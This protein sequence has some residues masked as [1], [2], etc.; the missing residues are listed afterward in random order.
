[1]IEDSGLR[2]LTQLTSLNLKRNRYISIRGISELTNLSSIF[3]GFYN[4]M[5]YRGLKA[6]VHLTSL[7]NCP[8]TGC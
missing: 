8:L 6:L 4:D 1:M 3:L 7:H 5:D 2:L